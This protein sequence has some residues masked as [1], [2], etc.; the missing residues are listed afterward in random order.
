M[1]YNGVYCRGLIG[2]CHQVRGMEHKMTGG[3][4]L[5]SCIVCGVI[6]TIAQGS[7]IQRAVTRIFFGDRGVLYF[8]IVTV[9]QMVKCFGLKIAG[10][11]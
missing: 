2:C 11:V 7:V 10:N 9:R 3:T 5:G 4:L 1:R 8:G 6:A